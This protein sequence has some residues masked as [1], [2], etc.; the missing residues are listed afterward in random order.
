MKLDQDLLVDYA[1]GLLPDEQMQE[2]EAQLNLDPQARQQLAAYLEGLSAM[3]LDLPPA[4]VP[5]GAE[6]RLMARLQQD[7]PKAV[8]LPPAEPS[9]RPRRVL[10]LALV[11]AAVAVML[12]LVPVFRLTP[13]R[14]L[15]QLQRQPGAVSR[16]VASPQGAELARL[17]RL[18]NGDAYVLMQADLPQDRQYQAWKVVGGKPVSL[19]LFRG[20]T[21]QTQLPAGTVFAVSV[22]PQG[23]SPQPTSA[24]LFAQTL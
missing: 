20:R 14:Q 2:I 12:V 7:A 10:W 6:D 1:L 4:P 16:T 18:P 17:V 23:G 9:A 8:P 11:A 22:E 5:P 15:A 3:A 19:G 13:E 21:F 24:P